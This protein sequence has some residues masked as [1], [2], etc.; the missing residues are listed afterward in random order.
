MVQMYTPLPHCPSSPQPFQSYWDS[1]RLSPTSTGA[2]KLV[3]T[4]AAAHK[5]HCR[6]PDWCRGAMVVGPAAAADESVESCS[7]MAASP[8]LPANKNRIADDWSTSGGLAVAMLHR[9]CSICRVCPPIEAP[10]SRSM[11]Y[12]ARLKTRLLKRSSSFSPRGPKTSAEGS[13]QHT[14]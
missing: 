4:L 2:H 5:C 9:T 3:I 6:K 10:S 8:K 12:A 11:V 1:V 14:W 7:L 13:S